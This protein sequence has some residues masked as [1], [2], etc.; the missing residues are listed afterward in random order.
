MLVSA[1]VPSLNE[2]DNIAATL[3]SIQQSYTPDQ[4]EIILVDGGSTDHT[5][6]NIPKDVTVLHA[7][8]GRAFQMNAGAAAA[9]GEILA[10]IHADTRMLDGWREEVIDLLSDP[11][12]SG[13]TFQC[14][15]VPAR[16]LMKLFNLFTMPAWWKIMYGDQVQFMRKDTFDR[17]DGF[18]EIP[19]MEDVE[20]SRALHQEGRLVRSKMR[21][22]TSGRRFLETGVLR[23]YW[24]NFTCMVRY[25]YF[26]ATPEEIQQIYRS[27][28]ERLNG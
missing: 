4:L 28:R 2:E 27:S 19:L 12:V 24:I 21:T 15:L 20:M 23:Q 6:E 26:G 11:W 9:R 16:G 14:T 5:L 3:A 13:G 8:R 25:L 10:F 18:P 17:I 7:P 22:Y 1:I